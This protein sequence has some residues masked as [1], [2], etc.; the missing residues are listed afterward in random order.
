MGLSSFAGETPSAAE[1]SRHGLRLT[2]WL[3]LLMLTLSGQV[4]AQSADSQPEEIVVTGS[5]IQ[6]SSFKGPSPVQQITAQDLASQ[7]AMD[8]I[9]AVQYLSIN[10]GSDLASQDIGGTGSEAG[11]TGQFNLRGLG[12]DATLTLVDGHRVA[13]HQGQGVSLSQIP[14]VMIERIDVLKTGASATYGSDAV[15]GVVNIITR[16]DF[17]GFDVQLDYRSSDTIGRDEW[18]ISAIGGASSDRGSATIAVE[19]TSKDLVFVRDLPS[20]KTPPPGARSFFSS[21]FGNP[22]NYQPWVGDGATG[23][24]VGGPLP[25]PECG[26]SAG[27]GISFLAGGLCSTDNM[28]FDSILPDEERTTGWGN[29]TYNLTRNLE[30]RG[31]ISFSRQ[32]IKTASSP[33]FPTFAPVIIPR[34]HPDFPAELDAQLPPIATGVKWWGRPYGNNAGSFD[35]GVQDKPTQRDS[36][37]ISLGMRANLEIG[38]RDWYLDAAVVDSSYEFRDPGYIGRFDTSATRLQAALDACRD[39]ADPLYNPDPPGC[40]NPFG[41]AV[42]TGT[43]NSQ[44]IFDYFNVQEWEVD[45]T[46]LRTYDLVLSGN[47]LDLPSGPLGVAVGMQLRQE[48]YLE[49][50]P[51]ILNKGDSSYYTYDFGG[52]QT[53]WDDIAAARDVNAVFAELAIPLPQLEIQLAVRSEDYEGVGRTTDPKIAASFDVT[54]S[55]TL[56]GS[57]ST[58]F[59]APRL[60]QL[61]VGGS[62]I[63]RIIQQNT[64]T[65]SVRTTRTTGG[66]PDSEEAESWVFGVQFDGERFSAD[67]DVWRFEYDGLLATENAQ[68]IVNAVCPGPIGTSCNLDHP[69]ASRITFD[70]SGEVQAIEIGF[71]NA[72]SMKT[73]GVDLDLRWRGFEVFG[74]SYTG[75]LSATYV[76]SF[77]IKDGPNSPE[78]EVAGQLN[79]SN[80][81][82]ATPKLR[83]NLINSWNR[84][85]HGASVIVRYIDGVRDELSD[86]IPYV[87]SH[88]TV[89]VNYSLDLPNLGAEG[90]T[91]SL[92]LINAFGRAAP[93]ADTMVS[94]SPVLHDVRGRMGMISYRQSF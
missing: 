52:G 80:I 74:G 73:Q 56:R 32:R 89:D 86:R 65:D 57:W 28:V 78:M 90:A 40:F 69:L 8:V 36:Y 79:E 22:G 35:I 62:S 93:R 85:N 70:Q 19:R 14:V 68:A 54:D 61:F 12:L 84:G 16:K 7:G 6:R 24:P 25:D 3:A 48:S 1:A 49:D 82:R 77:K 59:R 53:F 4:A 20:A 50:L 34:S 46:K 27:L 94:V 88:T 58:A 43:P 76:D 30:A 83:A 10:T 87:P 15:A 41:N 39:P 64:G 17:D 51:E 2:V 29:F 60:D 92:G 67:L 37:T 42:T 21:T 66:N 18:S 26:T 33:T 72:A 81:A 47:L 45:E 38:G 71:V 31:Q 11:A 23:F 44:E 91:V 13:A 55:I 75:T 63:A 5:Y 9:D